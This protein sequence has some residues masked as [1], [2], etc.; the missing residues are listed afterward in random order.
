[1]AIGKIGVAPVARSIDVGLM[2]TSFVSTKEWAQTTFARSRLPDRRLSARLITYASR[3]ASHPTASTSRVC[4][5]D[6]AEREGAYRML[7]NERISHQG[8]LEGPFRAT[9]D[10]CQGVKRI[11]A[12]QDS[13]SIKTRHKELYEK[14]KEGG[15]ANGIIVHSTLAVDGSSGEVLGLADQFYWNRS[16]DDPGHATRNQRTHENK[17]SYKW[18]Q[19]A[20]RL[21]KREGAH[22]IT[23]ADREADVYE[24]LSHLISEDKDFVIRCCSNRRTSEEGQHVHQVARDAP[25][26]GYRDVVI[27][28]RGGQSAGG[29]Q[30]KRPARKRDSNHAN[31]VNSDHLAAAKNKKNRWGQS[32]EGKHSKGQLCSSGRAERESR[33]KGVDTADKRTCH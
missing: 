10:R 26:L 13:T 14:V 30:A 28:Q 31:P 1:M 19:A 18:T 9:Q 11:L 32:C 22:V 8:I 6:I 23:V 17:E 25:V 27:D 4:Q 24:F 12:I 29:M 33:N 5:A 2:N 7:E 16:K 15:G 21:A 20:R 3:Q